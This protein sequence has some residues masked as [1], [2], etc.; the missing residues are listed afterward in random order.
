MSM[1]LMR[2]Q[3]WGRRPTHKVGTLSKQ[4]STYRGRKKPPAFL[5]FF[6]CKLF[7]WLKPPSSPGIVLKHLCLISCIYLFSHL[8]VSFSSHMSHLLRFVIYNCN[9]VLIT[10]GSILFEIYM[11]HFFFL[12]IMIMIV[13]CHLKKIIMTV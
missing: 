7:L 11:G 12:K 6:L 1:F 4:P 8:F 9:H 5:C 2:L 10:N 13:K 3:N